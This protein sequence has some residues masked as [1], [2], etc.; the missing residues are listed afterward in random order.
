[1][2][3]RKNRARHT[4]DDPLDFLNGSPIHSGFHH[5]LSSEST[6]EILAKYRRKPS[7]SS[8]AATSDSAGSNNSSSIKSKSSDTEHRLSNSHNPSNS[9]F[10]MNAKR[11]LRL[12]L[13]TSDCHACDVRNNNVSL[14]NILSYNTG[15][16]I[17]LF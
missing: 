14:K 1:M 6:D 15:N 10:F 17:T 16:L 5:Q 9:D 8:D 13:S 12:V 11:K 3:S 4:I 2:R 7:S